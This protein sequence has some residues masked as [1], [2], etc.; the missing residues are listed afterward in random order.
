ML[1]TAL[2]IRLD[3]DDIEDNAGELPGRVHELTYED[4]IRNPEPTLRQLCEFAGLPWTRTFE[5]AVRR[6]EFFDSTSTW[7]KHLDEDQG[8]RVLEFMRRTERARPPAP[9]VADPGPRRARQR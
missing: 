4:L 2:K 8:E 7:R 3:L 1:S 5:E 9:P 6:R